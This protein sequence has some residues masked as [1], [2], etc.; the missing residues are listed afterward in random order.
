M[1]RVLCDSAAEKTQTQ[2]PDDNNKLSDKQPAL[3]EANE[4]SVTDEATYGDDGSSKGSEH[5]KQIRASSVNEETQD[6]QES[7]EGPEK[8]I[9]GLVSA[10]VSIDGRPVI[11]R[12]PEVESKEDTSMAKEEPTEHS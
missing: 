8:D 12:S 3:S 5:E 9:T 6:D 4:Q 1:S 11:E 10:S 2:Q 7:P